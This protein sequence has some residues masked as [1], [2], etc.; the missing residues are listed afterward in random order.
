MTFFSETRTHQKEHSV[1][2][3][4]PSIFLPSIPASNKFHFTIYDA[5]KQCSFWN[6][7]IY[8]IN[9]FNS[10]IWVIKLMIPHIDLFLFSTMGNPIFT[11]SNMHLCQPLYPMKFCFANPKIKSGR[12]SVHCQHFRRENRLS[13][14][15]MYPLIQWLA[16]LNHKSM[17]CN[18]HLENSS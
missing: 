4:L 15:N 10:R 6:F 2:A 16:I 9:P 8:A 14:V 3:C 18:Y 17:Q 1:E 12:N 7:S 11:V 13:V 5:S